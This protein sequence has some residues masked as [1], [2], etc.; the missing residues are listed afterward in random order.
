MSYLW[1]FTKQLQLIPSILQPKINLTELT[2]R[3]MKILNRPPKKRL[4]PWLKTPE[5]PLNDV[6]QERISD[7]NKEFIHEVLTDMYPEVDPDYKSPLKIE[8]IEPNV[9][10]TKHSQRCGVLAKK[11]GVTL[12]WTKSGKPVRT[13]LLQVV[14]NHVIKYTPP[15][16]FNP[17]IG[18]PRIQIKK[19][20]GCLIVGAV[21]T[22]PQFL[23]KD[24]SDLFERSGVMPKKA[25][26]RFKITADA[27]LQPGTPLYATHFK[28]GDVVDIRAK[29]VDRG[30][31]GVMK[32]WGFKG[33]P[34]THGQTKTHRRP[35]NIGSGGERGVI[36]GT[37]MPGHMGNR[38]RVL[39]GLQ[40]LRINTK[41]NVL[42]VKGSAIPG[43]INNIIQIFDTKL[44]ERKHKQ[45]PAFPTYFPTGDEP[46]ELYMDEIHHFDE[47]TIAFEE[48][49]Q[50]T[51]KK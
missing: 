3:G 44:I 21:S 33:Q 8:P 34:A 2:Q 31:Q 30:F 29:T 24:Y 42:F 49:E 16:L 4:S 6:L 1:K 18:K 25:L 43:E 28:P 7:D 36:P 26:A 11:I 15:E 27:A 12:M 20:L 32:R 48:T 13:T 35:G 50:H 5:A 14:D 19:H 9:Q 45:G 10:W 39:R 40:I 22:D 37:K 47:P 46:E 17:K 23:T 41:F 38:Y 51:K